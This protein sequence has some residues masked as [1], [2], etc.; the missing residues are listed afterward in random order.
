MGK[1]ISLFS[2]DLS[3]LDLRKPQLFSTPFWGDRTYDTMYGEFY[4]PDHDSGPIVISG[5]MHVPPLLEYE[6]LHL[7]PCAQSALKLPSDYIRR[8]DCPSSKLTAGYPSEFILAILRIWL[9]FHQVDPDH[10]QP[11]PVSTDPNAGSLKTRA[12]HGPR[13]SPSSKAC[14]QNIW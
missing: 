11:S 4:R 7:E 8:T 13:S 9:A 3:S 2:T 12:V 5:R 1:S 14:C 10:N 6:L